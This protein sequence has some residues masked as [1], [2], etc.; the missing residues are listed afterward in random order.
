[1]TV[2]LS[3]RPDFAERIFNGTKRFEF[4]RRIPKH[5]VTRIVV[6]VTSPV[7]R[8]VGEFAVDAVLHDDLE[9]LWQQT[10]N[11]AGITEELFYKYFS[12]KN[13]G[14]AFQIGET[15]KYEYQH[16]IREGYGLQPPQSFIY[17]T[18]AIH[19]RRSVKLQSCTTLLA[20]HHQADHTKA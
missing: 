2:L 13:T 10:R 19:P 12:D 14:Y 7:C 4:R 3:I 1:M 5:N 9:Y 8:V 15:L 20:L 17:L 6:Y 18:C 11:R 16:C